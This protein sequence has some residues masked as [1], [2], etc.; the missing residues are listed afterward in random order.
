MKNFIL[1]IFSLSLATALLAGCFGGAIFKAPED[2][3]VISL[4]SERLNLSTNQQFVIKNTPQIKKYCRDKPRSREYTLWSD[5]CNF[6]YSNTPETM[7]IQYA[8]LTAPEFKTDVGWEWIGYVNNNAHKVP[9]SAWKTY[10]FSPKQAFARG[11]A[12]PVEYDKD[13]SQSNAGT[14]V[15][16]ILYIDAN[17]NISQEIKHQYIPPN[18]WWQ[19]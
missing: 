6:G 7:T 5:R 2:P 11:R 18:V 15:T 12:M 17:G 4:A 9:P 13:L 3:F 8:L 14:K 1:F 19:G 10:T 16:L